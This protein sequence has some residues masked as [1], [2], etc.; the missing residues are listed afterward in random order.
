MRDFFLQLR[1]PYFLFIWLS[2]FYN[3]FFLLLLLRNLPKKG[4]CFYHFRILQIYSPA[5]PA[6]AQE[7]FLSTFL[8]QLLDRF[9]CS[10]ML[11]HLTIN[12]ASF[13]QL[14]V[15]PTPFLTFCNL[16]RN[17]HMFLDILELMTETKKICR[18]TILIMWSRIC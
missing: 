7:L 16:W 5:P 17:L 13:H 3:N 15:G 14:K 9:C 11:P 1:P 18:K 6:P 4:H 2:V 10:W 12:P 8:V